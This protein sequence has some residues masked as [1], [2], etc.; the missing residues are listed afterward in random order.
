MRTLF[1]NEIPDPHDVTVIGLV[2]ACQGFK[3]MLTPE[4]YEEAEARI[5]LSAVGVATH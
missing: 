4:E 1:D 2:R 5:D 3:A